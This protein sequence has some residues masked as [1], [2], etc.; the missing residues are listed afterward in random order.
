MA[1]VVWALAP[2]ALAQ[3]LPRQSALP[4]PLFAEASAWNQLASGVPV[5]STSDEQV[6]RLY[7]VLRGDTRTLLPPGPAPTT[8]PFMDVNYEEWSIPVFL[9]GSGEARVL[10]CDYDGNPGGESANLVVAD[11]GSV[12]AAA[13]AGTVR[14]A[15]PTGSESDGHLVL[16]DP[17]AFAEYDFWQA[18]TARSGPCASH[19]GGIA[20][21]TVLESGAVARF[22]VNGAGSNVDGYSSAR[23]VGT[24]LLARLLVP[25]NIDRGEI[26]HALAVAIPGLR[27]TA[28]DPEEPT[29]SDYFY[30]ASTTETDFYNTDPVSLAAG[31]RL[32]LRAS[33]VDDEGR[34]LTESELAPITRI[35]L[36]A[37]RSY[38]LY[39][40]DNAGGFSVYA[41]DVHT[42][43][44]ALTDAEVA[45]LIGA[46]GAPLPADRTRWQIVLDA[47]ATDLE[48]IHFADGPWTEG[49]D[50]G[51]AEIT[52]ANWEVI[53][54]AGT[55]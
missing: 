1:G 52:T 15:G 51:A 20:G 54:N 5:A 6:L 38:G 50:A 44:L 45:T 29:A 24:P 7:R 33:L 10:L 41:E 30:P 19:G 17:V 13:P 28:S 55:P 12:T 27:N 49:Q 43:A 22:D 36:A 9:A 11:D 32:R 18:T 21:N 34:A 14:P 4:L 42:A 39:I 46:P 35:F 2:L 40:V 31:Q 48:R 16:Y 26:A 3:D 53:E 23:A 25:D 37:L 8:W 47:L